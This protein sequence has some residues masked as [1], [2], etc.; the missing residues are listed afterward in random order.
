MENMTDAKQKG[1]MPQGSRQGSSKLT[2][3]DVIE[4]RK[5]AGI[6]IQ[7][8]HIADNFGVHETTIY[9]ILNGRTW[10]WLK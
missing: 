10:A 4:I 9:H 3:A 7:G 6:G 8:I 1:R 2:A 5:M